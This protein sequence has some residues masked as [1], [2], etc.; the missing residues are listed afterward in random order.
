MA[1]HRGRVT[2]VSGEG[3]VKALRPHPYVADAKLP[4]HLVETYMVTMVP[5]AL[6]FTARP[7][8]VDKRY[9]EGGYARHEFMY[10][11]YDPYGAWGVPVIPVGTMAIYAGQHRVEEASR[12][13]GDIVRLSRH[14]FIVNGSRYLTANLTDYTPAGT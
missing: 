9:S 10:L 1:R 4:D 11:Y 6:F 14:T 13:G 8:V 2:W 7:L 3:Q 12:T 5:G